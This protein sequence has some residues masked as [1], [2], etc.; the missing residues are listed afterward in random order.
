MKRTVVVSNFT[1]SSTTLPIVAAIVSIR[2]ELGI[3]GAR[4][5]SVLVPAGILAWFMSLHLMKES[6]EA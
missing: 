1:T 6:R 3:I 5:G 2:S 4:G